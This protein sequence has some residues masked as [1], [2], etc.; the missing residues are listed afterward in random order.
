MTRPASALMAA[1]C[2]FCTLNAQKSMQQMG[3]GD[4]NAAPSGIAVTASLLSQMLATVGGAAPGGRVPLG[5]GTNNWWIAEG[6]DATD[7]DGDGMPDEWER[8]FGLDPHDPA[9]ALLDHDRDGLAALDEFLNRTHPRR[10]DT[11]GDGM[12]MARHLHVAWGKPSTNDKHFPAE[13]RQ[14]WYITAGQL[15]FR[16]GDARY[17]DKPSREALRFAHFLHVMKP[18]EPDTDIRWFIGETFDPERGSKEDQK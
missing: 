5:D 14:K 1:L 12:R 9:D 11:D 18:M 7:S 3:G 16:K 17:V 13:Q 8:L 10:R 4:G 15:A 2:V 6:R